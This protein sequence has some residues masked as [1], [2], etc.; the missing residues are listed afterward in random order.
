LCYHILYS[1]YTRDM[2]DCVL[3]SGEVDLELPPS[4]QYL[5]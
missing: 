4:L 1:I 5:Y 3:A 2:M